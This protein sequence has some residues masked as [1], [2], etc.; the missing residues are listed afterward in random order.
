MSRLSKKTTVTP[1]MKQYLDLKAQYADALLLFRLGDFYELFNEDALVASRILEITLTSRNKNVENPTPMC[2]VPHHAVNDYIKRLVEAGYKV[3][4]CEQMD[5]PKLTKG[6][7]RREVV[8]VV[9]PGTILEDAALSIKENHYLATIDKI[10]EFYLLAYVDVSTGELRITQDAQIYTI[11][12]ELRSIAPKEVVLSNEMEQSHIELIKERVPSFYSMHTATMSQTK[13][14]WQLENST[15]AEETILDFLCDYLL[16]VQKQQNAYLQP[17]ERYEI[18]DYLSLNHYTK[19][20]L[21][22]SRSLRTQQKK[23]SL[24]WWLDQTETA[25]GGRLLQRWLDQPLLNSD[26]LKIRHDK[27]ECFLSHYFERI[28]LSEC[29]SKVYDLE[30]LVTKISLSSATPRDIDQLR[31]SIQQIPHINE[32]LAALNHETKIFPLLDECNELLTLIESQLIENPPLSSTE[33]NVILT[34]FDATLDRYRDALSNG[35]QWL[36]E[37]QQR[38]RERTGLKTLKIGFNK[39]FGYYIEISRLQASQLDD[40]TYERKQTL[41]NNERFITQ[42]LKELE[43]TI[44]T[45]QEKA[46]A[47]EYEL[48]IQLRQSIMP[49]IPRLQ[50]LAH[51]IAELDVLS[52]FAKISE[53]E[54]YVRATI[55][56]ESGYFELTNSRHPVIEHLISQAEFV[57]NDVSIS[58]EQFMLLLTG[59]NMSGKSTYMRQIAYCIIMNQ[60]GCFVPAQTASLSLVDKIFTRIGSADDASSGQSTFMVE[61]METNTALKEAT[62]RSFLIFDELGRGTATYDGI[63]L[64]EAIIRY[65][66]T[67]VKATTIFSTHYHELTELSEHLSVLKNIHVGAVEKDG[68]V[69]FLHKILQ[70]PADKSYGIHVASLAG[71]PND[72]IKQSETILK[73]LESSTNQGNIKPQQ[74][75][76]VTPEI[77]NEVNPYQEIAEKLNEIQLNELSPI[78][79]WHMLE[80]LQKLL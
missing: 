50:Q 35:N 1:M 11:I 6:M 38:E 67:Q 47:L 3:A 37:L 18:S 80:N 72:L 9:T 39:V 63:A 55:V 59:P 26:L 66:A 16:S 75:N 17:V 34:G 53:K 31:R 2:G 33:G 27:V 71:L 60:M 19:I 10:N 78:E 30:R 15:K 46:L 12:N 29:F 21:E 22:L 28:E 20:Q 13:P 24:L 58:P 64:A 77:V 61:M 14:V 8:R 40:P 51:A 48:F 52:N 4:V 23:G 79:A 54:N 49:Y 68:K 76:L 25:M 43:T 32:V 5:D 74:V 62:Q 56:E 44:L 57:P 70:G 73:R 7:V 65:I 41:A 36:L 69:V 45:A 42:E